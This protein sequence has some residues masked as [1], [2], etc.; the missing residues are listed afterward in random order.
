MTA[1]VIP[2]VWCDTCDENVTAEEPGSVNALRQDLN[3]DGWKVYRKSDGTEWAD[4]C[5]ECVERLGEEQ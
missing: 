2:E 5:P 4:R 1:Y 3:R